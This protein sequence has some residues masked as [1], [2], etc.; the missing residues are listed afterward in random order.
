MFCSFAYAGNFD[1][2]IE[3]FKNEDYQSA[4]QYF[5]KASKENPKDPEPHRWLA[6]C[7]TEL[8]MID[9]SL[10]ELN[11]VKKLEENILLEKKQTKEDES[12]KDLVIADKDNINQSIN[13][14]INNKNENYEKKYKGKKKLKVAILDFQNN[15]YYYNSKTK[16]SQSITEYIMSNLLRSGINVIER[17]QINEITN[18][19][20]FDNSEYVLSK[21][22]KKIGKMYGIDYLI[23]GYI[24]DF[25]TNKNITAY[26]KNKSVI[27]NKISVRISAKLI[28]IET[29]EIDFSE[30]LSD[31]IE[32]NNFDN[33]NNNDF[34]N[35]DKII[36]GI[37]KKI[38]SKIISKFNIMF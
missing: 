33:E 27:N 38:S 21:S 28:N 7:Y 15:N 29:G 11:K 26:T 2:G 1:D 19:I 30:V 10:K 9:M 18:Q 6:K 24:L 14:I 22:A 13:I 3:L 5:L 35:E 34:E 16:I 32:T 36:S 20:K 31:S 8:F 23:L 25:S 37:S 17:S 12:K 4:I